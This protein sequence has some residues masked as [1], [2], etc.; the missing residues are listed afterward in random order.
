MNKIKMKKRL[1]LIGAFMVAVAMVALT[2]VAHAQNKLPFPI[3]EGGFNWD[4]YH[5]FAKKHDYTGQ[6]VTWT[7]RV[8]GSGETNLNN[9]MAYFAEATGAKTKH[10]GS[11][12]YKQDVVANLEGGTPPEITGI[13]LPGF[14]QDLSRRG[15]MTPLCEDPN[16]CEIADWIRENYASGD[17]WAKLGFWEDPDG[18]KQFYGFHYYAY[19]KSMVWYVPENFED[20]GYSIPRTQNELKALENRIVADGGTPWCHGLFAEGSTGFTGGD[21]MED[22]LLRREPIEFFDK[23]YANEIRLDD[24][25]IQG[26]MQELGQKI[27]SETKVDGGPKAVASLDWRTAAVGIFANPP[28]CF[29]YHQGSYVTSFLPERKKYGEWDF[30]YFPPVANRPDLAKKPV[31]GGGVLNAITKDSP[32]ARGFIEYLKTPIAHEIFMAQGGFVTPHKHINKDLFIDEASAKMNEIL[33]NA[34]PFRFD[35]GDVMPAAVGGVC[36]NRMMVDFV[37]G[38]SAGDVLRVCQEVW[39]KLK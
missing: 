4:S 12:T 32:A 39:D 35:P 34:D 25:R 13:S 20:S 18:K 28:K 21:M 17:A 3:G 19:I 27:L 23:L 5:A 10:V 26:A 29:M 24:L 6:S 15:F 33:L 7:T 30:F 2:G 31:L 37:G 36:W 1:G 38:K 11:Q 22:I 14:G 16:D 9:V 8:T